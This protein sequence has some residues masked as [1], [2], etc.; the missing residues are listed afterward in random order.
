MARLDRLSVGIGGRPGLLVV[1][2]C[3]GFTD[4]QCPLGCE[5]DAVVDAI[6]QLLRAFRMRGLPVWY[7][8]VIYDSPEQASVFREKL[9]ALEL[10]ARGSPWVEIDPRLAPGPQEPVLIKHFPS[11]FFGTDLAQQVASAEVDTLYVT[12]LTTSGCV[13]ASALDALQHNL[14]LIVPR[15]ATGDRDKMA[16]EANLYDL[17]SKYGDVVSL[18]DAV[19]MLET[20]PLSQAPHSS[21]EPYS[22]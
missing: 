11:A 10:L 14:R 9:P 22:Q 18:D 2:A 20:I 4:P 16:H 6:A 12:G 7:T 13:R 5:A 21:N 19:R 17:D 3:R 8:T 15:E 1:D